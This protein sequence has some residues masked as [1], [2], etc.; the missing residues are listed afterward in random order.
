MVKK[1]V[2]CDFRLPNFMKER[3]LPFYNVLDFSAEGIVEETLHGHPDLFLAQ[4]NES[5]VLA[6]NS[7]KYVVEYFKSHTIP[8]QFGE[9][10]VGFSYPEIARY[11]IS[12]NQ[13]YILCNSSIC[14]SHI[15]KLSENLKIISVKQGFCRCSTLILNSDIFITS[16]KG[17]AQALEKQKLKVH[18]FSDENILLSGYKHGLLGGCLG[19][20]E[21]NR[22]IIVSGSLDTLL[23][24][25]QLRLLFQNS[26]YDL[27]ELGNTVLH[28]VGGFF[29]IA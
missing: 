14:D 11:N 1:T 6:P 2:I 22:R 20:D 28:D 3:M 16:D 8:Y 13:K 27:L 5:F 12:A 18:L 24:G 10:T 4:I 15:L 19:I 21:E 17:I 25:K 29:F 26:A 9:K 23:E 7:P